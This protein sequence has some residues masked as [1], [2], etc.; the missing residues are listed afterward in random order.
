MSPRASLRAK[1][2]ASLGIRGSIRA[3]RLTLGRHYF[4]RGEMLERRRAGSCCAT[5]HDW[6]DMIRKYNPVCNS[7]QVQLLI[8]RKYNPGNY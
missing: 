7:S 4:E 1:R 8:I 6:A 5:R 3:S 2:V